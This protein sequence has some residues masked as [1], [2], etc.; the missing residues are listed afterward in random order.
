MNQSRMLPLLL[1]NMAIVLGVLGGLWV[2]FASALAEASGEYSIEHERLGTVRLSLGKNGS[3]WAGT[4]RYGGN[5]MQIVPEQLV[6]DRDLH[7]NFQVLD[8]YNRSAKYRRV[9]LDGKYA[10]GTIS[11]IIEDMGG[12]YPVKLTRNDLYTVFQYSENAIGSIFQ[13]H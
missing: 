11:G 7:I 9:T 8:P 10:D 5:T 3:N 4:L 2:L 1:L 13:K 12:D 6:S